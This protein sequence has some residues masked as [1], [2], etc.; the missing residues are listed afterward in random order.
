M[1]EFNSQRFAPLAS[2]IDDALTEIFGFA[3]FRQGQREVIEA[4]VADRDTVVVMPTGSGK[5]LC[6]MLP[7]CV[8]PGLVVAVSPLIALMKDQTDALEEFGIPATYINSSLSWDE[9]QQR[10]AAIRGGLF[11]IVLVAPERFKS[12][13]FM[14]AIEGLPV[15]L[16]AI[17]EAHC[18]SSWGHDFR[19]DYLT[20]D[21]VREALGTPTTLALTATATPQVQVDMAEQLDLVAPHIVVSGFERPNL[22]FEVY[23][24]RSRREKF[25]RVEAAI[26][27]VDQ[28]STLVY[29]ATRKQVDQ[30]VKQLKKGGHH[31][32]MY[33]AGLSDGVREEVQDAFMAG[34]APLLVATN[35]FGMGVDKS[36][37]RLIVH[38]NIPGSVE[39]Y[40]QEAG[41]AGRDGE[42]A[43]C[44]L[45]YNRNDRGIHEFF[46]DNSFPPREVVL[47]I[48]KLLQ[49]HGTGTHSLDNEML[50]DH[51]SRGGSDRVHPWAVAS[52]LRLLERGGHIAFGVRHGTPWLD[53]IDQARSRDLRI[54]W[55]DLARRREIQETHLEQIG[56]YAT[57][58]TCR[59][60]YLVRYFSDSAK[61]LKNCGHCDACC[62][63]P[64]YA[65]KMATREKIVV[66]DDLHLLVRKLLSGVARARGSWGTH[67]VAAMLRGSKAKKITNSSLHRLSTYGLLS[68]LRQTDLVRLL[69]VLNQLALTSQDF[70][71]CIQLTDRGTEIM[72]SDDDLP[73][74][75]E[76]NLHRHVLSAACAIGAGSASATGSPKRSTSASSIS[77][78]HVHNDADLSDT[79][80]RT[81]ILAQ[82]GLGFKEIA[83]ERGLT[84]SSVLRHFMVLADHG[85]D[86]DLESHKDGRIL[87]ELREIASDWKLG[88]PLAPLKESLSASCDYTSLKLH[89]AILLGERHEDAASQENVA[90]G[91][92]AGAE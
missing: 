67:A 6:Y 54:D 30:V 92:A 81:L 11:K 75:I 90:A 31:P 46:T 28:G 52:G 23:P 89:L 3:S 40:Y 57:G 82:Q 18:I 79:Y 4:V 56:R 1:N 83:E 41:R 25:A 45:L 42:P 26:N 35:A 53:V 80:L 76:E 48:W 78:A 64:A 85:H 43:H 86:L 33:H 71:G 62:G 8:M 87:P 12:N 37:V 38:F 73:E 44:L 14:N 10:L 49:K 50:A 58:G 20:L 27:S 88:D 39:A 16:F 36:D 68:E 21:R 59:Q 15:G 13:L 84:T 47:R 66:T 55:E 32:A 70:R 51:L 69:D 65:D 7:A 22:F 17:D 24:A 91:S 77:T 60:V 29:C 5:S 74:N 61:N 9:Q 19:P 2:S 34:D 72:K 63:P